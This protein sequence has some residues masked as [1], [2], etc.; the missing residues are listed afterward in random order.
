[1]AGNKVYAVTALNTLVLL[2][3][4]GTSTG[5]CSMIDNGRT[6]LL[7]DGSPQ[8]WTIDLVSNAFALFVDATG[9]FQGAT[10]V[11]YLDTF[12]LWNFPGTRTF[13][14]TLSNTLTIDPTYI[15]DKT[16]YPDPLQTLVVNKHQIF[17]IGTL[18]S[19]VWFDAGGPLFPFAELPGAYFEHGTVAR[20]S[21]AT[22]DLSIFWLSRDL[23]GQGM[24]LR[25][26]SYD[27]HKISNHALDYQIRK[28]YE[29][30]TIADAIGYCYQQ[31]GHLFYVLNFPSGDQTWVWD[32][33]TEQWHQRAWTDAN[34]V[35]HRDRGQVCAAINGKIMVGDWQT[36]DLLELNQTH[37]TDYLSGVNWPIERVRGF[38]HL[39]MSEINLGIPGLDRERSGNGQI[40]Q[41]EGFQLDLETGEGQLDQ[42][43]QPPEVTLRW[44]NN[45]GKT[46]DSAVQ[47]SMGPPGEYAFR[48]K[49]RNIG[50]S[51]DFVFEIQYNTNAEAACQGAWHTSK[52]L[53]Q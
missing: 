19:E 32:E 27:C 13:G 45:R 33:A 6:V 2:G 21:V 38:P 51:W 18:K 30:G 43:G 52:V 31:D 11:D 40:I 8:G 39:S 46:F 1:V 25:A 16:G 7:V 44:S 34:G 47:M 22:N 20:Y 24:V 15:A 26:R 17:L 5:I 42:A 28:M 41:I 10:R 14:S 49:Q 9:T 23:Q 37:W 36:G 29:A 35:H 3:T 12:I 50:Q 4:I 48:P 53:D